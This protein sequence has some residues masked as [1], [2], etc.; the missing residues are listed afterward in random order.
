MMTE[1]QHLGTFF[2]VAQ[3][4]TQVQCFG[5]IVNK[6]KSCWLISGLQLINAT[7]INQLI[8]IKRIMVLQSWYLCWI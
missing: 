8:G 3:V 7:N 5:G 1:S 2:C 4:D 6:E